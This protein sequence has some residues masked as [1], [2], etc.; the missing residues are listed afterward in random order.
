MKSSSSP[1]G[2][3][4]LGAWSTNDR[5]T[6]FLVEQLPDELWNASLPGSPRRTIKMVAGHMHNAPACGSR[7]WESRSELRSPR[8]ST[9]TE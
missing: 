5:V 9:G 1:L 3:S 4:I 8:R 2:A 7:L 6:T